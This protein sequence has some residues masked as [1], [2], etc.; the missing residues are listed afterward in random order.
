MSKI[1]PQNGRV[2][3]I[4]TIREQIAGRLRADIL[5][6][7]LPRGSKLREQELAERFG[8]SR[9]PIRDVLMQLGQHGLVVS[10]PN[11]GSRV[12]DAPAEWMQPL[13][14][15]VRREIEIR[16][17]RRS[18]RRLDEADLKRLETIVDELGEVC[19]EG[20]MSRIGELD[21]AFHECLLECAGEPDLLDVWRPIVTRMILHYSRLLEMEQIHAEHYAIFEA[22][23]DRDL[24]RAI[25]ALEQNIQ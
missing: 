19:R 21:L 1:P 17:L 12:S 13:V 7:A 14:V 18:I 15:K 11:C 20:D 2:A 16:A 10:E 3:P 23:R 4:R 8:V 24:S 22:V 5:S 9:G 25:A 6:G